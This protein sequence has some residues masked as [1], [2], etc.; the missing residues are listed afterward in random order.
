MAGTEDLDDEHNGL[1]W[2]PRSWPHKAT[3]DRCTAWRKMWTDGESQ[4]EATLNRMV[5]MNYAQFSWV[6]RMNAQRVTRT[7]T[8]MWHT[9]RLHWSFRC[10][11]RNDPNQFGQFRKLF[12]Q[13]FFR[14]WL[15]ATAVFYDYSSDLN[16][17]ECLDCRFKWRKIMYTNSPL[18]LR[19]LSRDSRL[20]EVVAPIFQWLNSPFTENFPFRYRKIQETDRLDIMR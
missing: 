19:E 13:W 15:S 14:C 11:L 7:C 9:E 18:I 16:A 20:P 8:G 6:K 12:H 4:L 5:M 1:L 2:N 17:R 10:Y 3:A